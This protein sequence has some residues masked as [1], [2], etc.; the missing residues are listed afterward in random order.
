MH[1]LYQ[2]CCG[3][4]V[5]KRFV[6]ACLIWYS[7]D[8]KQHKELQRFSTLTPDLLRLVDWLQATHCTHVALE[9]TGVYWKP[10]FNLMEGLFEIVLVNAQHMKAVPGRKTDAKDAQWIADLLQHGLLKASF[11]PPQP[12]RDLRDLTRYRSSLKQ[13]RTRYV[14]RI[15]TLLEETNIKLSSIFADM[16]CKTGRDILHAPLRR[17]DQA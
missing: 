1:V 17:G 15:H 10:I 2:C 9:S 14:N 8:G 4:D 5:H 12:Q 11:I 3:L 6:V 13:E 16:M 7:E